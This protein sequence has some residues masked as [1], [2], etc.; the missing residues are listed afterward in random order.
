MH[1]GPIGGSS[2]VHSLRP[3]F[4]VSS[5][6]MS[7][8]QKGV[9]AAWLK[10]AG[11]QAGRQ[12]GRQAQSPCRR[13]ATSREKAQWANSSKGRLECTI[14]FDDELTSRAPWRNKWL[15]NLATLFYCLLISWPE[16]LVVRVMLAN[17]RPG[18]TE[19]NRRRRQL[20]RPARI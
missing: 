13:D 16:T 5:S 19:I 11:E 6:Q 1:C 17:K 10:G 7:A 18:R 9:R 4:Y 3:K 20:A 14:G 15:V 2:V 8:G 12:A